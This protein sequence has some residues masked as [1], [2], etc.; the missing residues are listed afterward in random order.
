[1]EKRY[2]CP[3]CRADLKVRK[4]LIF[5]AKAQNGST[6]LMLFSPE[7]GNYDILH[8]P[9]LDYK[10]GDHLDFL[11]PVCHENLAV[12]HD[13]DHLAEV[14]MVEEDGTEYEIVF[15][16]IAGKKAILKIKDDVVVDAYGV[17]AHQYMNYWGVEPKY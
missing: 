2:I 4:S 15:S 10:K 3:K 9:S 6:G 14:L 17:D 13:K 11:C 7:L 16:E 8:S 1:M 12:K 5:S